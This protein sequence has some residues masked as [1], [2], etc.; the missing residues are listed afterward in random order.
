MTNEP[1][2]P[3]QMKLVEK[4][5][6]KP[7]VPIAGFENTTWTALNGTNHSKTMGQTLERTDPW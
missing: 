6:S 5:M 4:L 7:Q 2:L 3:I 1:Q